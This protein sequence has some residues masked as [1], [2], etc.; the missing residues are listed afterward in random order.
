MRTRRFA[1]Q[2][3]HLVG[4][5]GAG[6]SALVPLLVQAGAVVSGCDAAASP[7]TARCAAAGVPVALGHHPDHVR[8]CDVLVHTAAVSADHPEIAAARAAGCTVMTRGA[9]LVELMRG[10]RTIAVAGSHGKSTTTWMIGHLLTEAGCD[11]MVM[12]GGA[13]GSLGGGARTGAGEL[14]VAETD[15]SD[16]SFAAIE[17]TVAILTNLDQEHLRHYGTFAKLEEAMAAWLAQLPL[18]GAAVVPTRGLGARVLSGI[19]AP[20]I[21]CAL[22]DGDY[23]ARDLV[24][25]ADGSRMRVIAFGED[26]GEVAVPLPGAHMALNALMAIAGAR[27]VHAQVPLQALARCERVRRRFTVHGTLGG[28]RVVEDYGHHPTEVAA[29]I[30]AAALGGGRVHVLFQPHRYS[31]TVDCFPQFIHCFDQA[32]SL[33]LL[34][35]YAASEPAIPGIDSRLLADSIRAHRGDGAGIH[36]TADR[37]EAVELCAREAE[38]GDTILVLG[39]GDVGELAPALVRFFAP[40]GAALPAVAGLPR[41]E[42]AD[43]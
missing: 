3:V 42:V 29:T 11:P 23:H 17:P 22:D 20:I 8:A 12:V 21:R 18:A 7:A 9:C 34:P 35:I 40:A 15:E 25:Q 37:E 31:R 13:V 10:A 41:C 32:A 14:F 6:M 5:G 19:R 16:G 24:L 30:S 38:P 26:L 36:Y 33:V 27:H 28:V 2:R 4:I 39:A 43:V 1:G